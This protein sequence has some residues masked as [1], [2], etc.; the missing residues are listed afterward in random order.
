MKRA[1]IALLLAAVGGFLLC[2]GWVA[3]HSL[4]GTL[5]YYRKG[6]AYKI[7]GQIHLPGFILIFGGGVMFVIAAWWVLPLGGRKKRRGRR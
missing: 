7:A 4:G 3:A 6:I 5:D 2:E 1:F